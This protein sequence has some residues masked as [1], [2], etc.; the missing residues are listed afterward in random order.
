MPLP[1]SPYSVQTQM[2]AKVAP[3]G[4]ES[5]TD[6]RLVA[7][8]GHPGV[9]INEAEFRRGSNPYNRYYEEQ[10]EDPNQNQPLRSKRV[11]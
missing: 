11:S 9:E 10:G 5:T 4:K 1:N 3:D 6:K 8:N 7:S 2:K